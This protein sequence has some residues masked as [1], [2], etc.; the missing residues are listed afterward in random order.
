MSKIIICNK[1]GKE[2]DFWD[3]QE[4]FEI[5]KDELGYGTK[6]DGQALELNLCCQCMSELISECKI[7]PVSDP[8]IKAEFMPCE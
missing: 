3:S 5:Q 7:S 1:C 6:H 8:I 4:D 2:F